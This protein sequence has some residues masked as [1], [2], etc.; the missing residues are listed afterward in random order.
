LTT[1]CY[2]HDG[3][4]MKPWTISK[5]YI[6]WLGVHLFKCLPLAFDQEFKKIENCPS[7]ERL[8]S[9]DDY[10]INAF[11]NFYRPF[12]YTAFHEIFYFNNFNTSR[13]SNNAPRGSLAGNIKAILDPFRQR[14]K[15]R[16]PSE[17][18]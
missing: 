1:D 17:Y 16:V 2:L 18:G 7:I 8:E 14:T 12:E 9:A 3:F 6:N 11:A 15:V 4:I 13:L 5:D 10:R